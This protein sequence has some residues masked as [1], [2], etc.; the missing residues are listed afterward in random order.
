MM[1][2][3]LPKT[4]NS[5]NVEDSIYNT[6]EQSGY[7]NPN[8]FPKAKKPFSIAMPPPNATGT[9]HIG[10]AMMLAIQ[11]LMIRY[12]RMLGDKTLWIPGTDH[13]SIA[14]QN[15]VERLIAKEGISRQQL[16]R[17][18]FLTRVHEFVEESR[19]TIKNQIRK[20]G[21]SCDWSRERYTLDPGLSRAVTEIF[22]RMHHDGL[23]YRDYRIVN[24]CPRCTSTLADDEV[25]Y[26][27]SAGKLYFIRYQTGD[28]KNTIIVATT[29]PETMLGDVAVAVHPQDA[30]FK[31]YIGTSVRLPLGMRE[32]P[33]IADDYVEKDFGSGALKI[34]P[35]HDLND[36]NLGKKYNLKNLRILTD[37]G[38]IDLSLLRREGYDVS[39]LSSYEG[40]DRFEART[41]IIEDL[42]KMNLVEKI[43]DYTHSVGH[44]YRCDTVIEPLI[45][46]QWF[47]AVNKKIQRYDASLKELALDTI[48]SKKTEIIP[49]RFTKT[50]FHWIENLR[51]W[52]ISRQ[53]WFGHQLPVYYCDRD[54]GGCGA[55]IV[56]AKKPE[57]CTTCNHT[58][59]R[60]DE[61]TLDTW[62]S[63]GLWTFSTLGW[64][65]T[66]TE[67][68]EKTIKHGDLS[69]FHPTSVLET[70][71]DILFF[72]IAR[73]IIMSRYALSEEPFKKVYLHG[74]VLDT[75]GRKMSK[76][77]E[78]ET[79]DPLDVIETYGADAVRL[80]LLVGVTP[81]NN[82]RLNEKKIA[83]YRNFVNKLWNISR[84]IMEFSSKEEESLKE[85]KNIP[86]HTCAD[87]WILS[88]LNATISTVTTHIEK[89]QFSQAAEVLRQFTWDD[90]ADWYLEIA[91]IEK[92]KQHILYTILETLL[93]LWHPFTPF[94]T[95]EIYTYVRLTRAEPSKKEHA[96]PALLITYP[97]PVATPDTT[98]E[99]HEKNFILLQ[100][101]IKHIRNVRAERHVD[102]KTMVPVT[103]VSAEYNSFLEENTHV[104]KTLAKVS[105]LSCMKEGVPPAH[106]FHIKM[107]SID[108][109]ITSEH[110][111]T[112]EERARMKKEIETLTSLC[113]RIQERLSNKEFTSKAP[114]AIIQQEEEKLAA[115]KASLIPLEEQL[116]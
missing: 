72:W 21:S 86:T 108:I 32:I 111:Q 112:E 95:E 73:M 41:H 1:P 33:L 79:I 3:P 43:E 93:A 29:R 5:K 66:A 56:S 38:K 48:R 7:F 16:G 37:E 4:Y 58:D 18:A 12:H 81:G 78:E 100:E 34:T 31:Q 99:Y 26:M 107:G 9:L 74:L 35:A 47:V 89:F 109:Y 63:S 96:K 87:I 88:R 61:D 75:H 68:H 59:L 70:G 80:S 105:V 49:D 46:L 53:I 30:R 77:H 94:V 92:E 39:S 62:F 104:I 67:K 36:F 57:T 10:H 6:W 20:M 82:V 84:F 19:S 76:S 40:M 54:K 25:T 83:S 22:V 106:T 69:V 17:E 51:D 113:E 11:D 14:T 27:E 116:R 110:T 115:Y 71:Y 2:Q 65:D 52:C 42:Q 114:S 24:W 85:E 98:H 45:S 28:G 101:I 97:W 60:Q 64:P 55:T 8:S 44:C 91:K 15:K 50:Y 90:L 103:L 13:A 102:Q 23:I